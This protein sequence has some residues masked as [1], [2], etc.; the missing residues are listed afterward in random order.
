[1]TSMR[2]STSRSSVRSC[3][4]S[5]SGIRPRSLS[6][7]SIGKTS[8]RSWTD[9]PRASLEAVF[10][11]VGN[12]LLF[13]HPSV[14]E[15]CRQVLSEA[16]HTHDLSAIDDLMPL[17]DAYYEDRYRADDTFWTSEEEVSDVWIGMYSLLCGRLG[18]AEGADVIARRVYDEFGHPA[19]W[20][21][22]DDVVPAFERLRARGV[23]IGIVSNWDSR[24]ARSS[25]RS[26]A[27]SPP[28]HVVIC[29]AEVG[30]HKPDPRIFEL[31][32][33][34]LGVEPAE[35]A[36]VG[37]HY[38]ADVLGAQVAGLRPVLLDRQG[39]LPAGGRRRDRARSTRST[40]CCG[41]PREALGWRSS[42]WSR[43]W[44]WR[45]R[46]VS[47]PTCSRTT[48]G[49]RSSTTR[50]RTWREPAAREGGAAAQPGGV[51]LVIVDGLREDASRQM[52]SLDTLREY[53]SDLTLTAPQPSLSYPNWTTILSGAPQR[54]SGVTTNGFYRRVPVETLLDTA[55]SP[56]AIG[57]SSSGRARL[58]ILYGA[59][60]A[61]RATSTT[62]RRACTARPTSFCTP[63]RSRPSRS[64]SS[65]C[66]TSR[67]STRPATHTGLPRRDTPR[68]PRRST[69]TSPCWSAPCR[70][71]R[72]RSWSSPTTGT[73]PR[74]D[75]G[76][77]SPR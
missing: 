65:S 71:V 11:D 47:R 34:R 75:T 4:S 17:V 46:R 39:V 48:R 51:V 61:T 44:S 58:D 74:A 28:R 55:R 60:R 10:F 45:S 7:P 57:R 35:A 32:C 52:T 31:A 5:S 18:I 9:V 26:R 8:R 29:S 38:Y 64:R 63:S 50:A 56:P 3:R 30:L 22:F 77:G 6:L 73:S 70:T 20:R 25:R 72:R 36:H 66:C 49:T 40:W 13:P 62:T 15:V 1:M 24:L 37:D 27:G 14:A 21:A 68:P 33:R 59:V 19:R 67:T 76:A 41:V 12:T 42:C 43:A 54:I 69:R 53:G 16:G 23:R 2:R